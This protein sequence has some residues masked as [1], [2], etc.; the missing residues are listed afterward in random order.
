M[1]EEKDPLKPK[2]GQ[3]S[4]TNSPSTSNPTM[5][6][7][8]PQTYSHT[9]PILNVQHADLE[10]DKKKLDSHLSYLGPICTDDAVYRWEKNAASKISFKETFPEHPDD[11]HKSSIAVKVNTAIYETINDFLYFFLSIT[12]GF[13]IAIVV[14]FCMAFA[15]FLYTYVAGPLNRMFFILL[16]SFAP[17]WRAL[18]RIC[19]DPVMESLAKTLSSIQVRL[20]LEAKGRYKPLDD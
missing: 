15:R 9:N 14:G 11:T 8:R 12:L 18:W 6:D 4:Y 1:S 2:Q 20:G 7:T 10:L 19:L 17:A 5:E 3:K 13:I 16:A